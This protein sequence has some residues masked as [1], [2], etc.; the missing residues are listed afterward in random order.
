[1]GFLAKLDSK[2]LKKNNLYSLYRIYLNHFSSIYLNHWNPT[3]VF[4][5]PLDTTH[6]HSKNRLRGSIGQ[7]SVAEKMVSTCINMSIAG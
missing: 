3:H 4:F 7:F 2:W 5:W 1:M 6:L